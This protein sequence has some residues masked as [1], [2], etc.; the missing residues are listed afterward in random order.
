MCS[1]RT[2]FRNWMIG[3]VILAV[4]LSVSWGYLRPAERAIELVNPRGIVL[5]GDEQ[6]QLTEMVIQAARE[7]DVE[8]IQQYLSEGFT[9]NLRSA[10]GDTLL[11]VAAYYDSYD[12]V[13]LLVKQPGIDLEARNRMG[14]TALCAAAYKGYDRSLKA[15]IEAGANPEGGNALGQTALMFASLTNRRS[16][17]ELL[18]DA[19]A[20][21][22]RADHLGNTPSELL[23]QQTGSTTLDHNE[24]SDA[25]LPVA[26]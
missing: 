2:K 7:N 13:Q 17:M 3:C 12:C 26:E 16:T 1:W 23:A 22:Q 24:E 4:A 19:G 18:R 5:T 9:P 21:S 20:N 25:P 10:R 8:T 6:R 15:L 14:L 11:T